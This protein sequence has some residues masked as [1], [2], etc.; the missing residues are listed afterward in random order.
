MLSSFIA[1]NVS[2]DVAQKGV[3]SWRGS[4]MLER[5]ISVIGRLPA[6]I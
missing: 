5:S 3:S 2:A 4:A 6:E 1:D